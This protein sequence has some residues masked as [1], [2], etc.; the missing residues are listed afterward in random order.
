MPPSISALTFN[1]FSSPFY[2]PGLYQQ[3][4]IGLSL[5]AFGSGFMDFMIED[6]A[7]SGSPMPPTRKP[8]VPLPPYVPEELPDGP[9]CPFR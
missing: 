4:E 1:P 5:P 2:P 7:G 8:P 6:E 9:F 3:H